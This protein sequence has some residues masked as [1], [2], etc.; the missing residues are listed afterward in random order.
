[1]VELKGVVEIERCCT[2][3]WKETHE[4][5]ISTKSSMLSY[6]LGGKPQCQVICQVS[7]KLLL[8]LAMVDDHGS[9][10]KSWYIL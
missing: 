8:G 2:C 4:L 5:L 10:L 7:V 1:M 6:P 9:L 3:R